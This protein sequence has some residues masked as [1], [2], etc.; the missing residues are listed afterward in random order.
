M[1]MQ[2]VS[3]GRTF[4]SVLGRPIEAGARVT[5]LDISSS[6]SAQL[7]IVDRPLRTALFL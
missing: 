3:W 4:A 6:P 7:N 2:E 5:R 1:M